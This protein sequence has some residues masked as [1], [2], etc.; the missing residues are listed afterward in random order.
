MPLPKGITPRQYQIDQFHMIRDA[1][2]RCMAVL[3][4]APTG[5]G[6][7]ILMSMVVDSFNNLNKKWKLDRHLYFLVDELFLL[8]QF[9]DHLEKW[10][11]SHDIIGGGEHEGRSVN[12]H[13]CTIQSLAKH[14]PK[15]EPAF[16][17]VDEAHFSTADRYMDLFNNHPDTKILGLTASPE[18][19]SG[20]GLA[21]KWLKDGN[22]LIVIDE[23]G[24]RINSGNGIFDILVESPV[25]MRDLTEI[26]WLSRIRY[27]GVPIQG[28]E[29]LNMLQGEYKPGEVEKLLQERGTF[30]DAIS[31]M[32]KFPDVKS[33]ILFFC[34]SVKSCYDMETV[35]HSHAYTAEVLE[36]KLTKKQRKSVMRNFAS[37]KTQILVT[38]KMVLKGVDL[39]FLLLACDLSPTP[40]RSTQRQKVGRGTRPYEDKKTGFVK[41][42]FIYLDMVGN[43]RV[44]PGSDIYAKIEWNFY[45]SKYNKKPAGTGEENTCPLC[46][47]LLP[48]G[49]N[50][51]PECGAERKKVPKKEKKGKHLDG[52]L[53]EINPVPLSEREGEDLADVQKKISAAI[54][55]KNIEALIKIGRTITTGRNLPFWIY[56][57]LSEKENIVDIPLLYRIQR[58]LGYKSYW[59]QHAKKNI[60][61]KLER[62]A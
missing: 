42:S 21:A 3:A 32:R 35:L 12:I 14:P 43:H 9:S 54:V 29:N 39:P 28:I 4:E 62:S 17:V 26:G 27:F 6:K 16:F 34:K 5:S 23:E 55:D 10:E 2:K 50:I 11:I 25:S 51:C 48:I 30:G 61:S 44:F 1:F 22:D 20:R 45:S 18:T 15:Q 56:W 47:A 37:G 40:A 38:C 59:V 52:D 60:R 57:R 19:G 7:S 8:Q 53:V 36:G 13:V 41:E 24:N 33:H 46:F 49:I 58:S 31:E